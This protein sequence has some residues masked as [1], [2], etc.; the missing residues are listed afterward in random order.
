MGD[1]ARG[2]VAAF[3]RERGNRIACHVIPSAEKSLHGDLG[4]S[5]K[6]VGDR[7]GDGQMRRR[8]VDSRRLNPR[9]MMPSYYRVDGLGGLP[10][11]LPESPF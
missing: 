1:A 11:R 2:R 6:G 5:L 8:L 7:L 3:S 4:P 9:S 10:L